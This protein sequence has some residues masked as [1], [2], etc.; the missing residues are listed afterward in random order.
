[1]VLNE[2][3]KKHNRESKKIL[4]Q[5]GFTEDQIQTRAV[6]HYPDEL[7]Y[8]LSKEIDQQISVVLYE[9]LQLENAGAIRRVVSDYGLLKAFESNTFYVFIPRSYRNEQS[10]LLTDLLLEKD[11]FELELGEIMKYNFIGKKI[12]EAFL[13][14]TGKGEEFKKIEKK[15]INYFVFVHDEGGSLLAQDR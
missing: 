4:K 10:K 13:M 1:M 14:S 3:L 6:I 2:F 5:I 12:Y 15:L 11:I 8:I 7:L 9:L